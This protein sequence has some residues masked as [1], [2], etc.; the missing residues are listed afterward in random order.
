MSEDFK[1]MVAAG[2]NRNMLIRRLDVVFALAKVSEKNCLM[3]E[4]E[5]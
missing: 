1:V 2:L 5:R 4:T 3:T